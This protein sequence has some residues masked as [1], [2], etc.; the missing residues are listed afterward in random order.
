VS[1]IAGDI[2]DWEALANV[3]VASAIAGIGASLCFSFAV[4]G[5]IR[6]ADMRRDDRPVQATLYGA[7]GV[8]G[9]AAT[10]AA[11]VIAIIVMTQKS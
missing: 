2:V 11:I 6:F 8:L 3:I 9:L 4:V 7:L 1:V 5:A 10:I